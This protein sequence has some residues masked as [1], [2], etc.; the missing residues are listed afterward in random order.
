[1]SKNKTLIFVGTIKKVANCGESMKNHLFI[2]RFRE[3]FDRVITVD[4]VTPKKRPWCIAKMVM[5]ILTHPHCPVA[6]SVSIDT[7]DKVLHLLQKLGCKNIYYWAV[8]GT[9]HEKLSKGKYD[10][11]PYKKL[12]AIYV[13]S[14]R[15]VEGLKRLGVN[16]AI[17]VNNSKR[18]DYIPDIS[19][20]NNDKVRFVFLSRV[21]PDKGCAMIVNSSKRLNE[22][23]Y[24]DKFRVDFY[25][26]IDEKY[27]DF[28]PMI[29]NID[30]VNYKGF[31]DLTRNKGYDTLSSYDMMLFPTYWDG[32]GF[33]GIV[34]DAYIS[35]VPIVASNWNCNE[36]V[37]DNQTGVVIP[38]H[39]EE[40]LFETM[41]AVLDGK[42]DLKQM[43]NVCQARAKEYDNRNI[44]SV[45]HLRQIGFVK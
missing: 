27:S 8:G 26:K 13:Q 36:D 40:A 32:E 4:I 18:I 39:N 11:E 28:L 34:I 12:K 45:E 37:I 30:N 41:K 33:P 35:G 42:Y 31:L 14:P 24:K 25:G 20:R 2:D 1:M 17:H 15:I 21:H 6:M 9:L 38:H 5:A 16:N 19:K 23:G 44:L 3:V 7:G 10:L 29:K 22:L 43:A